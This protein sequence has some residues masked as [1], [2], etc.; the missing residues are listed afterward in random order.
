MFFIR[1][2]ISLSLDI[3]LS[4]SETPAHSIHHVC[5]LDDNAN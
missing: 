3:S 2:S 4:L 5:L 1:F